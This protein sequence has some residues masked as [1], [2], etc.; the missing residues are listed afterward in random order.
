MKRGRSDILLNKRNLVMVARYYYWSEI[1]ERRYDKV[2]D[3]LSKHEFFL[4]ES[5]IERILL[6]NE[7]YLL[8]LRN[9]RPEI[10]DFACKFPG[11]SWQENTKFGVPKKQ[12]TL[13]LK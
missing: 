12:Y 9:R 3:T 11:F 7:G 8:E 5:T 6:F 2:L 10:R 4:A 1:W 13:E